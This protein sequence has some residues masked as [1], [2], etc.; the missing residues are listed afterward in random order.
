MPAVYLVTSRPLIQ[1]AMKHSQAVLYAVYLIAAFTSGLFEEGGRWIAYR[2][3]VST[4]RRR[5]GNGVMLGSGHGGVESILVGLFTLAMAVICFGL[6]LE[7]FPIGQRGA[8]LQAKQSYAGISSWMPLLN[9]W[10]RLCAQ[11]IQI[12]LS[13]MVLQSFLRGKRY[14]FYALGAHT[15]VDFSTVMMGKLARKS[16]GPS[17]GMVSTELLVTFY[18]LIAIWL[19]FKWREMPPKQEQPVGR[20]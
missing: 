14:W 9:G 7:S 8:I 5:W 18:A 4:D 16:L 6:P 17:L 13:V 1:N 19:I 20:V 3:F 15:L 10:E 11:A 2:F 12:G